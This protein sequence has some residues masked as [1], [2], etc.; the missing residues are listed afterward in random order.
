MGQAT[1]TGQCRFSLIFSTSSL[2]GDDAAF[3]NALQ[4]AVAP[5]RSDP[6]VTS[7]TTPYSVP[8]VAKAALISKD[9]HE[10]LVVVELKDDGHT[11]QGYI[12]RLVSAAHPG[13][14]SGAATGQ[15]PIN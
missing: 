7:V 6:R 9:S 12:A 11:A 4:D 3:Q 2:S 14:L 1:K 13:P 10:A 8:A 15:L 5:L